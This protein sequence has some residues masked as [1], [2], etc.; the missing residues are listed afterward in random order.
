LK[1][2]ATELKKDKNSVVSMV[3]DLL[4]DMFVFHHWPVA[5]SR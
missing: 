3:R 1:G 4:V 2:F 5:R